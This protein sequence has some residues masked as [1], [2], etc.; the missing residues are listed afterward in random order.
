[1]LAADQSQLCCVEVGKTECVI[2]TIS[3]FEE[4]GMSFIPR[5]IIHVSSASLGKNLKRLR[6]LNTG[7]IFKRFSGIFSFLQAHGILHE[8]RYE[9]DKR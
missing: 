2:S 3:G 8:Q 7:C 5:Q 4:S 9:L 6:S 1:M